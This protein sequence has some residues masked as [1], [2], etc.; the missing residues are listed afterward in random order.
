MKAGGND[1]G[2]MEPKS[3][4]QQREREWQRK[5][6]QYEERKDHEGKMHGNVVVSVHDRVRRRR[7]RTREQQRK[8]V[9]WREEQDEPN[10]MS[11]AASQHQGALDTSSRS[12]DSQP[13][14]TETDPLPLNFRYK[15]SDDESSSEDKSV[16]SN[17][18]MPTLARQADFGD[19]PDWGLGLPKLSTGARIDGSNKRQHKRENKVARQRMQEKQEE[20][21]YWTAYQGDF[22]LP[23]HQANPTIAGRGACVQKIWP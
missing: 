2:W 17:D 1:R 14:H 23:E 10:E 3:E 18:G 9:R 8:R 5:R 7:Q 12:P 16:A 19:E 6:R 22:E 13:S 4:R 15:S 20:P 11:R 21:H